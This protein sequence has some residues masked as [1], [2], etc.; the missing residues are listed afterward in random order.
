MSLQDQLKSL[1]NN[2]E[3]LSKIEILDKQITQ[4]TSIIKS[5]ESDIINL[6][7]KLQTASDNSDKEI[8][9]LAD[10]IDLKRNELTIT[11]RALDNAQEDVKESRK[12]LKS[13]RD[14]IKNQ[15]TYFNEEQLKINEIINKWNDQLREFQEADNEVKVKRESVNRDIIRLE[16]DKID[17]ETSV[18]TIESRSVELDGQYQIKAKNYRDQLQT[19]KNSVQQG[20]QNLLELELKNK[21]RIEALDTR[22]QSIVIRE[23]ALQQ[24]ELN[25]LSREKRL[26]MKL[27]LS[28]LSIE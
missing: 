1:L 15:T 22:E 3:F 5:L 25:I 28:K 17:L 12:S 8:S 18:K 13:I 2:D 27:G 26:N 24:G 21:A 14:D 20:E 19:I 7:S 10:L 6:E 11:K 9:K 23:Q 4:K 16:Q